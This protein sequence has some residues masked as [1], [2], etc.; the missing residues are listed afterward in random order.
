[1]KGKLKAV[2]PLMRNDAHYTW[3]S[4]YGDLMY[5]FNIEIEVDDEKVLTG[6]ASAKRETFKYK[7]GDEVT[8][9]YKEN[10]NPA[11]PAKFSKLQDANYQ[12]SRGGGSGGGARGEDFWLK[13]K[14]SMCKSTGS[15]L[16]V[17]AAINLGQ[18]PTL[19]GL[20]AITKAFQDWLLKDPKSQD[21]MSKRMS[22]LSRAVECIVF[23]SMK[24]DSSEKILACADEWLAN[25][26]F[27]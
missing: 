8:F 12:G 2:E 16:A 14:A 3:K 13:Q 23:E 20:Y 25:V 19:K 11:Y 15:K 7:P 5:D 21:E 27:Q 17:I 18:D 26:T 4:S 10:D 6:V 22:A 9:E 24:I 1:M